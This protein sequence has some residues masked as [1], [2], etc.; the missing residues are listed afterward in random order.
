MNKN[1]LIT[2]SLLIILFASCKETEKII[3]KDYKNVLTEEELEKL[4]FTGNNDI[5]TIKLRKVNFE[6]NVN[7]NTYKSGGNIAILRDSIIVV[8]LIPLMGYEITRIFCFKDKILILDRQNKTYYYSP[9][10]K[11]LGKYYLQGDFNEI[12]SLLTGR[13]F[14]YSDKQSNAKLKKKLIKGNGYLKYHFEMKEQEYIRS[15]QE[16]KIREDNLLTETNEIIDN[17]NQV[18][19]SI[20]Y[21]QF[22]SVNYFELPHEININVSG[23]ND[24]LYLNL[25]IA[26]IV[27]NDEVNAQVIIPE[28]YEEIIM[29]Y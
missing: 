17:T 9:Y 14:I 19:I 21:G 10:S 25:S 6:I 2:L 28:K 22:K 26:N 23:K 4:I 29:N 15:E 20:K 18:K 24:S 27:I 12:E 3:R 5:K 7:G 13:A 11:N 16:L 1:I 8:S